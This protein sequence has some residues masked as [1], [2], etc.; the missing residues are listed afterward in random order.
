MTDSSTN[1]ARLADAVAA[2]GLAV[3]T[4]ELH[5]GICG[6]LCAR[7]PGA[8]SA[9]IRDSGHVAVSQIGDAEAARESLHE[10]EAESWRELGGDELTFYPWLP[11]SET[12]LSVRVAAL[13][14]WCRGFV[15]GLGL[16]GYAPEDAATEA[17]TGGGRGAVAEFV[18][19][20]V[21]ISRAGLDA[22]ELEDAD[23]AGFDLAAVVEYVRVGVQLVFEELREQRERGSTAADAY[24]KH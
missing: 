5:G 4:S 21:E 15:A 10:A 16:G 3:D 24:G 11:G 20:L 12:E 1:Q 22:D 6:L 13:A 18:G 2:L 23:Q 19:D 14:A 9:W 7:G 8:A 17:D